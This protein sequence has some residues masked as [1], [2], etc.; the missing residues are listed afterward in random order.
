MD[1][2][3]RQFRLT[4]NRLEALDRLH[5]HTA[6]ELL[7]Y[8]PFR[9][10]VLSAP[11]ISL[12]KEKDKV[13]FEAEVVSAVRSWR[14][15]RLTTSSFDVMAYD[16]V[17]KITIFNRPWARNLTLNQIITISGIYNGKNKVTAMSYD[18]KPLAEH[19][20][21]TPVYNTAEGIKQK[22]IRACELTSLENSSP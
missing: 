3:D 21:V 18:T 1:L 5:I 9:Y 17:L 19:D 4:K 6:E 10:D 16:R 14:H 12:W 15:G 22:T 20:A 8:Y 13:T 7:S 11:D 2:K